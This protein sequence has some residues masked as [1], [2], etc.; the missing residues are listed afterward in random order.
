M[1]LLGV[2]ALIEGSEFLIL[3]GTERPADPATITLTMRLPPF[4]NENVQTI[5]VE[6][7]HQY[8][9]QSYSLEKREGWSQITIPVPGTALSQANNLITLKF[10]Q[11]AVSPEHK[12]WRTSGE[13]RSFKLV[14]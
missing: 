10:S 1:K 4:M 2:S 12:N 5:T 14:Q 7:N 6:I 3:V 11:T 9:E 8:V 13:L